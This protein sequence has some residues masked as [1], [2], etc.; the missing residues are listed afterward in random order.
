[1]TIHSLFAVLWTAALCL[2]FS[3]SSEGTQSV[4]TWLG[5]GVTLNAYLSFLTSFS[6]VLVIYCGPLF[7][8]AFLEDIETDCDLKAVKNFLVAPIYTELVFRGVLVAALLGAGVSP[9]GAV[10]VSGL[11]SSITPLADL[12]DM[13]F[14][15]KE[16]GLEVFAGLLAECAFQGLTGAFTARVLVA[17]GS[18]VGPIT[19]RCFLSF[20]GVPDL[21]F[22]TQ[23][24]HY[25]FKYRKWVT[26][27]YL[28]GLVGF[29]F[30]FPLMIDQNLFE[31]FH[32]SLQA[33]S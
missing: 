3:S 10:L 33:A 32:Y 11:A 21:G 16:K 26:L 24:G 28:I 29:Y 12:S 14:V 30:L 15:K 9:M 2:L 27:V 6:L 5:L 4:W 1:M 31:P 19:S 8:L 25:A 13:K 22:L 7:Q 20:M 18:L 17:T 23:P